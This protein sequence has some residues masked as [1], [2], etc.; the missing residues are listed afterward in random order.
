M[1]LTFYKFFFFKSKSRQ[2]EEIR[3]HF[4]NWFQPI[5]AIIENDDDVLIKVEFAG[6]CGTDIHIVEVELSL[7]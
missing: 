6:L 4:H 1:Q 2:N 7:N 5:V 3:I